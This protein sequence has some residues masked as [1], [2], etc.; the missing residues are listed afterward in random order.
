MLRR[1]IVQNVALI[2]RLDIEFTDGFNVLTGETGAGK[3]IVI[4][5]VNLALGERASRELISHGA[6]KAVVEAM[7]DAEASPQL[8]ALFEENGLTWE[9][10]ELLL[11]RE[12][13][14]AGKSV[15]RANGALITLSLLKRITDLLV[16]VHGQH[17]HQSLLSKARHMDYLDAFGGP[18]SAESKDRV[19]AAY[20]RYKALREELLGG[21]G[22][23]DERAREIDVLTYQINEIEQAGLQAGEEEALKAERTILSNAERIEKALETGAALVSGEAA[24]LSCLGE[25]LREVKNIAAYSEAYA[26]LAAKLEEAYY[27]AE[28]IGY[29][30]RDLKAGAEFD[31]QRADAIERRLDVYGLLR[32][33]YGEDYA[34]VMAFYSKASDRLELL[35]GAE[36]HKEKLEKD[37]AGA[38]QAYTREAEALTALRQTAAQ[39]LEQGMLRQLG[40]LGLAHARFTV[41]FQPVEEPAALGRERAEFLLS[42]NA[43]EPLMPLEKVASGGEMSRIMLALKAMFAQNDEIATLIFD[44]IDTGVSGRIAAV[45][46]DKLVRLSDSHQVLCVTHL[47]QIA[48]LADAHF[49]V[50]KHT[51]GAHTHTQVHMLNMERRCEQVAAMMSGSEA[52]QFAY[53]HAKELIA[54]SEAAKK[55]RRKPNEMP[56]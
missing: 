53:A 26:A 17:E 42:A 14:A 43:G 21:F 41:Q 3:S 27:A 49:L 24:A 50:E 28:D 38:L 25:A 20:A 51:D 36:A 31:P 1:L 15:C 37:V 18:R 6:Q 44:E 22:S 16:D 46:G 52:S 48:A 39:E 40:E 19:A 30:L 12:L 34:A 4:D 32:R 33:K 45:V 8:L 23:E 10:G 11:S 13:S 54:A 7:F 55:T 9:D 56:V 47:P 5:A 29:T 35:T 2:E